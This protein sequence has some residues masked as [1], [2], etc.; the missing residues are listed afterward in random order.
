M[1]DWIDMLFGGGQAAGA[2]AMANELQQGLQSSQGMFGQGFNYLNPFTSRESGQYQQY[3]NALNQ[4]QDPTKLYNQFA[5]SYKES[6]EALA[7]TQV[8]Q[9]AA[10]NAAAASGMLGSGASQTAAANLAQSVRSQDFDKYMANQFA[11]RQQYLGGLSGLQGQG[12]QASLAGANLSAQEAQMQQK[13]FEDM[14]NAR[15]AQQ[16]GQSRGWTN[17]IGTGLGF[18]ADMYGG[19]MF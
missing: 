10:N 4:S 6:P 9:K 8:G 14:A 19:G 18:A 3:L 5:A 12:F 17:A 2:G 1:A 15:A 13:Y 16:I 11:T 7:Q